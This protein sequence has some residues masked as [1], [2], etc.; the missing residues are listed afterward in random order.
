MLYWEVVPK[1]SADGKLLPEMILVC[2]AL[3][4]DLNSPNEYI[5][6]CMLRFLCKMKEQEIL[7]PLIPSVK[8]CL[9]HRHS[10]VRR[11]AAL[12]AFSIHKNFGEHLLPDGP[13]LIEKFISTETDVSARRNAFLMLFNEAEDIAIDFLADH[14]DNIQ[15]FG[16]G[17]A[18]L[19]LELSRKVC[20]RDPAQKSR[21]V[22]CLFQLLRSESPAVSYEAAWTLVSLSTAPTAVRSCAQTYA[23]LLNASS[24]NNVKLIVLDRLGELKKHHAKV[25]QEV[26]MDI[27]R[28]LSSPNIHICKKTLALAIDL[29]GPRNIEEVMTLLKKEVVRSQE[30]EMEHG[31]EYKTLLIQAIHK[32]ATRYAEVADSV[33]LVLLD[34][35]AGDSGYNVIVCV[36]SILEQYP[37]FRATIMR[38]VIK[39]LDEVTSADALRVALWVLSECSDVT[40]PTVSRHYLLMLT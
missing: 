36:K 11:N 1:L 25:V 9:E 19:V 30:T 24:D 2:N 22:R 3:R 35:L 13:E 21:F 40:D 34:F 8:A 33:V 5:R 26:L 6:G 29:V 20:R 18:L 32:C 28:A 4:N 7:E 27:L 37:N 23:S 38:K 39:N 12:A 31:E 17:F 14:M 16:D 15:T 10:Y